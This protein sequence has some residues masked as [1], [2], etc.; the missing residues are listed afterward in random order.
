MATET[1]ILTDEYG[2][3]VE[4][5][6]EGDGACGGALECRYP[7]SR[8]GRSFPR[9]DVHWAKRLDR[10]ADID[11]RYPPTAPRDFDP[12]YAGERWDDE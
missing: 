9:C 12:G 2:C 6:D 10:Q 5:L 4:C 1:A 11:R 7:L 3:E 8:T